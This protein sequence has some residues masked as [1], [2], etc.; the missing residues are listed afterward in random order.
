MKKLLA[1]VLALLMVLSLAACGGNGDDTSGNDTSNN[2]TSNNDTN[3]DTDGDTSEDTSA[4][5][6]PEALPASPLDYWSFEDTTGL[7]AVFQDDKA[8][9][10]PNDGANYDLNPS[11][12]EIM[13]VD[14]QGPVGK[15]LYLDGKYGVRLDNLVAPTD[16]TYTVSFWYNASRLSDFTPSVTMGRNLGRDIAN[17]TVS[18]FSVTRGSWD[19]TL[20]PIVWNRNSSISADQLEGGVFPWTG[21]LDGQTVGKQE[22]ALV[23]FVVDGGRY[24]YVDEATNAPM[25]ERV[26]CQ[27]YLN[28]ELKFDAN[29]ENKY[30][31]GFAPEIFAGDGTLE[32]YIGINYWDA[33]YK[34][35]IDELYVFDEAL[36]PGQV[37]TL[38]QQGNIPASFTEPTYEGPLDGDESDVPETQPIDPTTLTA[39]PV[40]EAA[41]DKLGTPDRVLAWWTDNSASFPVEEGKTTTLTLK[42]YSNATNNWCNFCLGLCANEFTTEDFVSGDATVCTV[43]GYT[44]YAVQRTDAYGWAPEGSANYAATYE[45]SWT[46]WVDWLNKMTDVDVTVALTRAANVVTIDYTITAAD[47]TVMT[48]KAVVTTDAP[49]DGPIYVF[50]EGEGAYI[51]LLSAETK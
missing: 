45:M 37:L 2:D 29:A 23:T 8:A 3:N 41:I 34:G 19:Q 43:E 6:T 30:Y 49:A 36:T 21:A 14:G 20:Y 16:D 15:C 47:G 48:E 35:F 28:G 10:S 31:Q 22:W 9:D 17:A 27:F 13:L 11:K 5:V 24:Q 18:W 42:N 1:L 25:G 38:Y 4:P 40:D 33:R 51:E 7:T 12:H 50:V 46:D 32:G 44:E 26:G 39:A